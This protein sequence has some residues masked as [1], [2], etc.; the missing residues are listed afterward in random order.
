[1][2]DIVNN[3]FKENPKLDELF[4]TSDGNAF[5]L[6]GDAKN[7]AKSLENKSVKKHFRNNSF[8]KKVNDEAK[9]K[10]PLANK[11]AKTEKPEKVNKEAEKTKQATT[12]PEL[13]AGAEGKEGTD[14]T[15]ETDNKDK[16]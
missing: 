10:T 2:Q 16:K 4:T 1:M 12:S 15:Q 8:Q 11:P 13:F 7:H 9:D 6:E 5:Y 3:I 14:V